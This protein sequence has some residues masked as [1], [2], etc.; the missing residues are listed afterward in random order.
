MWA[1]DGGELEVG[2]PAGQPMMRGFSLDPQKN[3]LRWIWV[4]VD[5]QKNGLRWIWVGVDPQ[6]NGLRSTSVGVD[7]PQNS[8]ETANSR[9]EW[10]V[11]TGWV[12]A[13]GG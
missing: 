7:P 8:F 3:E 6:K 4:G 12:N 5:P 2:D 1:R 11:G 9:S 10:R 13:R